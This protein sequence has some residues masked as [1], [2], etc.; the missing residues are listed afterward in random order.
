[1]MFSNAIRLFKLGGFEIKLDPSWFL[2]AGL[3]T[4]TL[5]TQYFPATL[6]DQTSATYLVLA[7]I[8]ML[9]FFGSLLLHELAHSVVARRFAVRIKAITL[10]LF[11]GVAEL[12]NDPPSAMAELWIAVAGPAMSMAL[13]MAFWVFSGMS[14]AIDVSDAFTMVLVYLATI[15]VIVAIFNLAPAFPMDGGRILRAY[16][17]HRNGDVLKATKTASQA[18]VF[19]G[20]TLMALGFLAVFQGGAG[21]GLWYVLIGFFVLGAA[22]SAYQS[23]LMQSTFEGKIVSSV[24]IRNPVE[25]SPDLTLS[26]F[27]N[28]VMLKYRI[29]FA[30]VVDDGV[31]IG[32][33]DKDVL[34]AI[35]R[36]NWTNTRIDD[37]FAGLDV[38]VTIRPDMP[39]QELMTL[40]AQTGT[41]KFLVVEDHKL[42]GVVTL[43]NLI[44]HLHSTNAAT[45][46]RVW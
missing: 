15:N 36:D 43:A 37:V 45:Q 21:S 40:I 11:G 1:M 23:Q 26:E 38:A 3:I 39:V 16:L 24:M 46:A 5:S 9:G 42:L 32:Q 35:D 34:A 33:I 6:P 19:F 28:Q 7:I 18:G 20:Y 41:R 31:L 12:E 8:A 10:F 22:K 17:W 30:P 44:G 4:W 2:I 13:G 25:V 27:V 14:Q 29:S